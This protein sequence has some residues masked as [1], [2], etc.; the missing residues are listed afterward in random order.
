MTP[1]DIKPFWFF[2]AGLALLYLFTLV[3]M[4]AHRRRHGWSPYPGPAP[5]P[6]AP[7]MLGP[8]GTRHLLYE[9]FASSSTIFTMFGV[10]WCPHCVSAKPIVEKLKASMTNADVDVRVVN[11]EKEPQ[12]AEGFQ[13][14]GYPTFYLEKA[15][16]KTKYS[17]PRTVEGMK[18]FLQQN[19][20]AV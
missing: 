7:Q 6:Y 20:V 16:Q 12:A 14:D 2:I 10:D 5:T 3:A 13:I 11:P 8:G 15:G 19:G 17:G 1:A 18:A 9:P 4:P